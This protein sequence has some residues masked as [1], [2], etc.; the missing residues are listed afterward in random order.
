MLIGTLEQEQA[1]IRVNRDGEVLYSRSK[2]SES[3]ISI[4]IESQFLQLMP[5]LW[6][7]GVPLPD[8]FPVLVSAALP[9]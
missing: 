6:T 9:A 7:S 8:W 5:Q 3:R 1:R 4:A 2:G